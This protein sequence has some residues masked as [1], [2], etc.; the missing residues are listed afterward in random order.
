M[1]APSTSQGA[2]A[3]N[4]GL[5]L[6]TANATLK[7]LVSDYLVEG[8]DL[9]AQGLDAAV[10]RI[11]DNAVIMAA[12]LSSRFLPSATKSPRG[13][14]RFAARSSSSVR[15]SSSKRPESTTSP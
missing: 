8:G 12:G 11:V 2:L 4:S 10:P 13:C 7:R 1:K 15:S 5:S 6:G 14:S 9:T 3:A